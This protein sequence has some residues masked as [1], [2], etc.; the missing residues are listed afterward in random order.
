M[1]RP[2]KR[3]MSDDNADEFVSQQQHPQPQACWEDISTPEL[4][5]DYVQ[6]C[7]T[8]LIENGVQASEWPSMSLE[9]SMPELT[10]YSTSESPSRY[11]ISAEMS[12]NVNTVDHIYTRSRHPDTAVLL[13]SSATGVIGTILECPPPAL[14]SCACLSTMYLTM[15]TL[16][17]MKPPFAFP[18]ALHP[19]REAMQTTSEVLACG[20]CPTKFITAMQNTQLVGTLLL[21][22]ADRFS[23]ILE[24]INVES[25]R[26]DFARETKKFRLSDLSTSTPYMHT[27][28]IGCLAAFYIDLSSAE[29]RAMVKKVVR[30]EVQGPVD[31]NGC[32]PYFLG[33]TQK[34]R[35]R[36]D[37]WHRP[38][39]ALA[40]DF[41]KGADGIPIGGH[42]MPREDHLC[43][44]MVDYAETV[45]L[46][47]DWS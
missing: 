22:I 15:N 27:G 34:M 7:S 45:V 37:R 29:W 6:M 39:F 30:A 31:G 21:S 46:D 16:S 28:G 25:S 44:K 18:F 42:R 4:R 20:Q 43:M 19:L 26:A 17:A 10:P 40:S 36:Q 2:K 11:N 13:D 41:A 35:N 24:A 47:F 23:K 8:S 32:R 5:D 38:D 1:G 33:L 14:R 9:V 3:Q 12:D